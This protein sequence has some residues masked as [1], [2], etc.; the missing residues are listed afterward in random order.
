MED[1]PEPE[2]S[3]SPKLLN[4]IGL[5]ASLPAVGGMISQKEDDKCISKMSHAERTEHTRC[6]RLW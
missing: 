1:N 2:D 4:A 3:K 5:A 6:C